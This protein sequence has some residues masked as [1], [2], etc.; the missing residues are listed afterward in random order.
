[1]RGLLRL[2]GQARQSRLAVSLASGCLLLSGIT[3][4]AP[5]FA[6]AD[7][8][9]KRPEPGAT[10]LVSRFTVRYQHPHP[11]H[12]PLDTILPLKVRLGVIPSGLVAPRPEF[13]E[14]RVRVGRTGE[15]RAYHAGAIGRVASSLLA[16]LQ[17]R[18]LLGVYVEPDPDDIDIRN[19]RD[20]RAEGD[21]EMG[22]VVSTARV[23]V[24]RTVASGNRIE[25]EW[26]IDNAAHERI[27]SLSPIQPTGADSDET[28]DLVN[29]RILDDYLFRLNRHPGRRVDAAL[30]PAGDGTGVSLDYLVA[31]S[32]PWYVHAQVSNT[33]TQAGGEWQ[34]TFGFTNLQLTGR[35]D[36]LALKYFRSGLNQSNGAN[37]SYEAPWF[38][39]ERPWWWSTPTDGPSW[40]SWWDRSEWPWFGNND[41]RWRVWGHYLDYETEIDLSRAGLGKENVEGK[42]WALGA[43]LIYNVFQYRAFFIDAFIGA[44]IRDVGVDNKAAVVS[45]SHF[46][47]LPHIGL[48]AERVNPVSSFFTTVTFESNVASAGSSSLEDGDDPATG[49]EALGRANPDDLWYILH[50][51]VGLTHYLE[52]LFNR[53]SWKDPSTELSSTLAHEVAIGA[54]GQYAFGHRVI[55]QAEQV[56]GGL[57]SVRG[58]EQSAAAG[59]DVIIGSFEYRFHLPHALPVDREPMR[60]PL[61]GDFRVSP[62]QVYGRADWDFIIRAFV[63]TGY[64]HSNKRPSSNERSEFLLGTGVG[65]ELVFRNNLRARFDWGTALRDTKSTVNPVDAGDDAF[66]LL[67]TVM[68]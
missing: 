30:A 32:K 16:A 60:L 20:L 8:A 31:E 18:G 15:P 66:H 68:Y 6:Q 1:M 35:D 11:D 49:I 28:T 39:S 5:A 17:Q 64:T 27:R 48:E 56:I 67:F 50:A 58:Y 63:D 36:I 13:R 19:E 47:F 37:F 34:Q 29:G 45:A 44:D 41:L 10:F 42:D 23:R 53:K 12:P 25:T 9:A 26:R 51:Q 3:L 4:A 22:L 65:A 61:L 14:T 62:Q 57:Y 55:P 59:D 2:F 21:T 33:G 7:G 40:L 24:L 43:R 38:D 46:F 54:R 52:P